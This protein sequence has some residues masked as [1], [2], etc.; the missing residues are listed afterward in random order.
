VQ[1]FSRLVGFGPASR[2]LTLRVV[3][4]RLSRNVILAP[5]R[6]VRTVRD[7]YRAMRRNRLLLDENTQLEEE[8]GSRTAEL[9]RAKD[10]LQQLNAALTQQVTTDALT[11]ISSR[12]HFD[13]TLERLLRESMNKQQPL[14][15][16]F[17][18][19]DH[20][21]AYNDRYGHTKG[22][23]C[24]GFVARRIEANL[25]RT[26][27]SVARYGG[28]E[29]GVLSPR[30]DVGGA[31]ALAERLRESVVRLKI[32]N[33]GAPGP[34]FVTVSVGVTTLPSQGN[35]RRDAVTPQ[36]IIANADRA[37]YQAKENGR[38]QCVFKEFDFTL[39]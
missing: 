20:F 27:D 37:L 29:F 8:I 33:E 1:A 32:R 36:K 21:K 14:S 30:T 4:G 26:A 16:L 38:N 31:M 2:L 5:L 25:Y 19:I 10:K 24:L 9:V 13:T 3:D 11:G 23:E 18:D 39:R 34:G 12:R 22:D 17:I 6:A 35:F 7:T 28:E 15:M